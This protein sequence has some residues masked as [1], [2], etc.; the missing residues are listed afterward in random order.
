M[1]DGSSRLRMA[2]DLTFATIHTLEA[3]F[4]PVLGVVRP[5]LVIFGRE[6]L[7]DVCALSHSHVAPKQS[8]HV[9]VQLLHLSGRPGGPFLFE[10]APPGTL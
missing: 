10:A 6:E 7:R 8:V 5:Q 9:A 3:M 1:R 4:P 2:G